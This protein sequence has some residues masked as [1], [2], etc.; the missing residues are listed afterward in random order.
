M[1]LGKLLHLYDS[2]SSSVKWK[3]QKKKPITLHLFWR[4][5]E[6]MHINYKAVPNTQMLYY[7]DSY[8]FYK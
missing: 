3:G 4:L 2:I 8:N 1:M 6:I 5:Y 7:S